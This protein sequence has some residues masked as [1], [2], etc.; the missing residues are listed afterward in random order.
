M[1]RPAEGMPIG[2]SPEKKHVN[3][4]CEQIPGVD[5]IAIVEPVD[6]ENLDS[7]NMRPVHWTA[8]AERITEKM[9]DCEAFVITHGTDTMAHTAC[10]LALAFGRGLSKPV[11]LTGAQ[12]PLVDFG[13]DARFNLENAFRVAVA[14]CRKGIAEVMISFGH[15]VYRGS[16]ARKC[17]EAELDA[18]HSPACPALASIQH[19]IVFSPHAL[20]T[21]SADYT[22]PFQSRFTEKGILHL[23]LTPGIRPQCIEAACASKDVGGVILE[24]YGSGTV[25]IDGDNDYDFGRVIQTVIKRHRTPFVIASSF[26]GGRTQMELYKTGQSALDAG[27]IP[28][29]DMTT[30]MAAVKLMWLL[31][32]TEDPE[33]IRSRMS[34]VE[35]EEVTPPTS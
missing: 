21:R 11:V 13:S 6:Y 34:C 10:A 18:F 24:S 26:V 1:P 9:H 2:P 20:Q 17:S 30:E 31:A 14:A 33:V 4:L 23:R 12:M 27:A 22:R 25:P 19:K 5:S 3:A 28:A 35:I 29:Y 16:R 8:L 15:G 32:Q 7:A